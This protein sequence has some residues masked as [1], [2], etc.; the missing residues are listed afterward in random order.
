MGM[1]P[2]VY[3]IILAGGNGTRM[4]LQDV[5]KVTIQLHNKPLIQ[6]G[7]EL[8]AGIT[9]K[10][11]VVVGAHAES[12][13][14]CLAPYRLEYVYQKERL[15]TAHA[16]Q[17]GLTVLPNDPSSLIIVGYGDHM[18]YYQ[19]NTLQNLIQNHIDQ[20]VDATFVTS[21]YEDINTLAYGRIVRDNSGKVKGIVEQK[22]ATEQE[23]K[24]TEFNAG[25]YCFNYSFLKE[26]LPQ[27]KQSPVSHEYYLTD[28]IHIGIAE[29][30]HIHAFPIPFHEVGVGINRKQDF[31]YNTI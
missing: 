15:G 27:I 14:K 29:H 11:V 28:L 6:Y 30:K 7:V 5:N 26:T 22:N 24:I 4:N 17:C 16:T 10:T 20:K 8:L 21:Y 9:E 13:K 23:K 25:L 19:K 18:M 12:V 31:W 1:T 3:G 2:N